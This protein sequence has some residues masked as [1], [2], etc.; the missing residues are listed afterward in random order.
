MD[1]NISDSKSKRRSQFETLRE[2]QLQTIESDGAKVSGS[3]L[4]SVLRAIHDHGEECWASV[5][6]IALETCLSDKTVRRSIRALVRLGHVIES[7]RKERLTGKLSINWESVIA[8][9][10]IT[11]SGTDGSAVI[12]TDAAV[13]MTL[14]AVTLT[15]PAV[16]VTAKTNETNRNQQKPTSSSKLRFEERDFQLAELMLSKVQEVAPKTKVK[17]LRKWANDIRLMR[18]SDAHTIKE[19]QAVF[20]WANADSFWRMNILSPSKL[21]KQFAALHARMANPGT[22][23]KSRGPNLGAGVV[24]DPHA[25]SKDANYGQM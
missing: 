6:T 4:K 15:N 9:V 24:H 14:S 11:A 10:T 20:Q 2:L 21:R 18:E 22:S 13:T 23:S 17:D 3:S 12:L 8:A 19:I 25:A 5:E 7:G 16:I 1:R